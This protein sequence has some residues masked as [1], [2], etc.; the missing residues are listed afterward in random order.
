MRTLFCIPNLRH[1]GAERQLSYLAAQV[2]R[3]RVTGMSVETT[4]RIYERLY[5]SLCSRP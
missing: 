1:G 3:A 5:L 4:A 2:A